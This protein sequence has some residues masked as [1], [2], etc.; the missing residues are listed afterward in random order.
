MQVEENMKKIKSLRQEVQDLKCSAK[1][2]N[3]KKCDNCQ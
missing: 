1:N 3:P 2:F